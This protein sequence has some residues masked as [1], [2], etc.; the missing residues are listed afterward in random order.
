MGRHRGKMS[1]HA[2]MSGDFEH[3]VYYELFGREET[4]EFLWSFCSNKDRKGEA[5]IQV[6]LTKRSMW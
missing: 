6:F 5:L 3:S 4:N 1:A 2:P